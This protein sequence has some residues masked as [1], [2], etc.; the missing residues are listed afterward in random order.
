MLGSVNASPLV[1]K[2]FGRRE[3]AIVALD[4]VLG[5]AIGAANV[6]SRAAAAPA[7]EHEL[8][9]FLSAGGFSLV[10]FGVPMLAAT[11]VL[12]P[13]LLWFL[14]TQRGRPYRGYYLRSAL[15]GI[16]FGFAA[17]AGVGFFSGL[18]LPLLPSVDATVAQRA[19]MTI[20]APGLL[21]LGFGL[22]S[23]LFLPQILVTGTAFGLLNGWLMRRPRRAAASDRA[24]S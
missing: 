23:L 10:L 2:W 14:H 6:G 4:G 12:A 20:G 15:A 9:G 24:T 19:L 22:S 13:V 16:L 18:L 21:T 8:A 1:P 7:L 17:S 11:L 3:A 5:V